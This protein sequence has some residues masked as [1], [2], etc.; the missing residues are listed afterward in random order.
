VPVMRACR[1]A[2]A[3]QVIDALEQ[4]RRQQRRGQSA[5]IEKGL[6]IERICVG[7]VRSTTATSATKNTL[8]F[9]NATLFSFDEP[10][11]PKLF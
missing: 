10:L 11:R 3:M 7:V 1:S 2:T 5:P 9:L 6:R 4:A 8:S